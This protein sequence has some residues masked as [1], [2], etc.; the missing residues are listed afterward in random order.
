ME[1]SGL[2]AS[3]I[4]RLLKPFLKGHI[5]LNSPLVFS[6]AKNQENARLAA[7]IFRG[8]HF[9]T[10][11]FPGECPQP[12]GMDFC[13]FSEI[14]THSR[15]ANITIAPKDDQIVIANS[16]KME[17]RAT[18]YGGPDYAPPKLEN[19]EVG[20]AINPRDF[21]ESYSLAKW[22]LPKKEHRKVLNGIHF[23]RK[24]AAWATD[25]KRMTGTKASREWDVLDYDVVIYPQMLTL[26][27][28]FGSHGFFPAKIDDKKHLAL[29]IPEKCEARLPFLPDKYPNCREVVP[30]YKSLPSSASFNRLDAIRSIEAAKPFAGDNR[31]IRFVAEKNTMKVE[32]EDL[33]ARF[34]CTFDAVVQQG[35]LIVFDADVILS[36]LRSTRAATVSLLFHNKEQRPALLECGDE[37]TRLVMPIKLPEHSTR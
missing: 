15:G 20:L 36:C 26:M 25:G 3:R 32:A 17:W 18:L 29:W 33:L 22:A 13:R 35:G 5:S 14:V 34:S 6:E 30:S 19:E 4:V 7:T 2:H 28:A 24:G 8:E 21:F 16:G 27:G 37:Q 10:L 9:V 11:F 23:D 1:L 12:F 31:L